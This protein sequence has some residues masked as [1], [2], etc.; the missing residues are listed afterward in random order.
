[1]APPPPALATTGIRQAKSTLVTGK[2]AAAL[3]VVLRPGVGV[4]TGIEGAVDA[5]GVAVAPC[6]IGGY[7]GLQAIRKN[8]KTA[9]DCFTITAANGQRDYPFH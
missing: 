1:M 7:A 5:I 6:P 4:G 2:F 3:G 8:P 9:T